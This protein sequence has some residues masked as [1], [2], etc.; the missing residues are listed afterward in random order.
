MAAREGW[1]MFP[2]VPAGNAPEFEAFA[3]DGQ[4]FAV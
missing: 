1:T 3:D 4:V 2:R